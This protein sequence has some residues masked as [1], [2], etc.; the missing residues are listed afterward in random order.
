MM[1]KISSL[2]LVSG[3][4]IIPRQKPNVTTEYTRKNAFE[5]L[6]APGA[7]FSECSDE[8]FFSDNTNIAFGEYIKGYYD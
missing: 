3:G 6:V 4:S 5:L 2:F 7:K 8:F 1:T